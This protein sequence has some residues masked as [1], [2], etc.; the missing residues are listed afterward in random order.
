MLAH[1][2]RNIFCNFNFCIY[3]KLLWQH[4]TDSLPHQQDLAERGEMLVQKNFNGL[5]TAV[6]KVA[7]RASNEVKMSEPNHC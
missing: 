7:F 4:L 2:C 5:Y 6:P 3:G 1:L